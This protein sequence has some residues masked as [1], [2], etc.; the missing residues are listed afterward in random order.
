VIGNLSTMNGQVKAVILDSNQAKII[1]QQLIEGDNAKAENKLF[2]KMDSI[3]QDRIKTL[4]VMR[5]NLLKAFE[6]KNKETTEL[7]KSISDKNAIIT[8]QKVGNTLYKGFSLAS[9]I[10]IVLL[11]LLK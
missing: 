10:T 3:N 8:K 9:T 6:E 4:G 11:L 2:S 5:D 7:Y 1:A